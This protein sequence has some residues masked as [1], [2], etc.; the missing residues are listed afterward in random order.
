[1]RPQDSASD[2]E[3]SPGPPLTNLTHLTSSHHHIITFGMQEECWSKWTYTQKDSISCPCSVHS[4]KLTHSCNCT[5]YITANT[6]F[7][8]RTHTCK[9]DA[10]S[11]ECYLSA[12]EKAVAEQ[13]RERRNLSRTDPPTTNNWGD[14]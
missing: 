14:E 9:A 2:S 6:F 1:M 11:L 13:F 7:L 8:S 12:L 3:I 5:Y 10:A 4:C